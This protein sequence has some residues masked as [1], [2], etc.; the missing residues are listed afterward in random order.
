MNQDP[1]LDALLAR[2]RLGEPAVDLR[3]RVLGRRQAHRR[4]WRTRAPELAMVASIVLSLTLLA[5]PGGGSRGSAGRSPAERQAILETWRAEFRN[6]PGVTGHLEIYLDFL[7]RASEKEGSPS[8][9]T[10]PDAQPW[11]IDP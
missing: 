6:Q 9:L 10:S 8:P 1:D 2:A 3:A 7:D 4:S 5:W 11:R